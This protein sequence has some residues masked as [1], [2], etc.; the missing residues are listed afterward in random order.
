VSNKPA[1]E[2]ALKQKQSITEQLEKARKESR[3]RNAERRYCR[4]AKSCDDL[5]R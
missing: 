5:D 1:V 4:K 2:K 3:E